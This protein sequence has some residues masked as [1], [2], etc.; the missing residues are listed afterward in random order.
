MCNHHLR[1]NIQTKP[2]KYFRYGFFFSHRWPIMCDLL[3]LVNEWTLQWKRNKFIKSFFFRFY[4]CLNFIAQSTS[5]LFESRIFVC[6]KNAISV[7]TSNAIRISDKRSEHYT[8]KTISK[9]SKICWSNYLSSSK[10]F[11][12]LIDWNWWWFEWNTGVCTNFRL[13]DYGAGFGWLVFAQFQNWA[14]ITQNSIEYTDFNVKRFF[15]RHK[16]RYSLNQQNFSH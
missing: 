12:F 9:C 8:K 15:I 6:S 4:L 2:E 5:V 11:I 13:H 10:I 7:L 3:F 16:Y 14:Q 1:S